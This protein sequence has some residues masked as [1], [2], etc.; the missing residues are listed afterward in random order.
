MAMCRRRSLA[1]AARRHVLVG[2]IH[3]GLTST[4]HRQ[5]A[6]SRQAP[7]YLVYIEDQSAARPSRAN[8]GA[9][10]LQNPAG[11]ELEP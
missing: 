10:S 4:Y 11:P 5:P 2:C 1:V 9:A 8:S 3:D 7:E 6:R